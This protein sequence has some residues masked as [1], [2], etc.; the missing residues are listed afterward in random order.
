MANPVL[1]ESDQKR[2]ETVVANLETSTA[3]EVVCVVAHQSSDTRL[4]SV[5]IASVGALV[6]PWGLL[7][8]NWSV[9]GLLLAQLSAFLALGLLIT[10]TPLN[11]WIIP[12]KLMRREAQQSAREQFLLRGLHH[13]KGRTGLL[14]FVSLKEHYAEI[15][16][17]QGF[18]GKIEPEVWQ[19][20]LD[21]LTI[22]AKNN[23]VV[24]GCCDALAFLAPTLQKV[25]PPH[26]E[27][28]N[29]LSNKPFILS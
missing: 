3:A 15:I 28:P 27:N 25:A 1:S 24:D 20:A 17:D 26:S 5:G 22:A 8:T 29:E 2:L 12:R 23:Q 18:E 7:W 6:V 9:T 19:K 11:N 14:L 4:L 21:I 10:A 16:A 13:T